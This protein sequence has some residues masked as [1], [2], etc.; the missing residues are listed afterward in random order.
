MM[1]ERLTPW[2]HR[3]CS[4]VINKTKETS[5]FALWQHAA[6]ASQARASLCSYWWV[7]AQLMETLVPFVL[8][9]TDSESSITKA[10]HGRVVDGRF[11]F[12]DKTLRPFRLRLRAPPSPVSTGFCFLMNQSPHYSWAETQMSPSHLSAMMVPTLRFCSFRPWQ[13][14]RGRYR[15]D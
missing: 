2:H 11:L 13:P 6:R 9:F 1:I 3:W 4:L 14:C 12:S 7:C 8:S 5:W 10:H 15:T